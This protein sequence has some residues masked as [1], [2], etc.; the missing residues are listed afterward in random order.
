MGGLLPF[1]NWVRADLPLEASQGT[2]SGQKQELLFTQFGI[3]YN[4]LEPIFRKG[5][6]LVW[7]DEAPPPPAETEG[8]VSP[9]PLGGVTLRALTLPAALILRPPPTRARAQVLGDHETFLSGPVEVPGKP[10]VFMRQ[11][12]VK[13][14]RA[15]RSVVIVHEDIIGEAWWN[16][17]RGKGL[18]SD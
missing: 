1:T 9:R 4:N 2:V 17:G 15:K 18:L 16:E 13:P 12:K 10:G 6:T 11:K 14:M 5:S 3:N 8:E 7:Q